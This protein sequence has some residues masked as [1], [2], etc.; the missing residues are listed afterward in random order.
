MNIVKKFSVFMAGLLLCLSILTSYKVEAQAT[1]AA[2]TADLLFTTFSRIFGYSYGFAESTDSMTT[3]HVKDNITYFINNLATKEPT[4]WGDYVVNPN[5]SARGSFLDLLLA[6]KAVQD[7]AVDNYGYNQLLYNLDKK[8]YSATGT[9]YSKQAD[10]AIDEAI[11]R[12][13]N[14][15][16][17]EF[18][19]TI[20][21]LYEALTDDA[22]AASVS[23]INRIRS[24]FDDLMIGTIAVSGYEDNN[25][26]KPVG[27][28]VFDFNSLERQ[29]VTIDG[30]DYLISKVLSFDGLYN[31][32]SGT[33]YR[34][35]FNKPYIAVCYK[36]YA[37]DK[38]MAILH[39]YNKGDFSGTVE[40]YNNNG[41]LRSSSTKWAT[42]SYGN[43]KCLESVP[44][45]PNNVTYISNYN[46]E[47]YFYD[48]SNY[49]TKVTNFL[50]ANMLKDNAYLDKAES[51]SSTAP[52]LDEALDTFWNKQLTVEDVVDLGAR[53]EALESAGTDTAIQDLTDTV[54]GLAV[55]LPDAVVDGKND[56]VQA[57]EGVGEAILTL[58]KAIWLEFEATLDAIATSTATATRPWEDGENQNNSLDI[59]NI[60]SGIILLL[61]I[62]FVLLRI[63]LHCMIFI[64]NV[65]RIPARPAF[66]PD[67]M[68][69]GLEYLNTLEIPGIGLSVYAFMMGLIYILIMFYAIGVLRKSV[70]RIKLPK[71]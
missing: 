26:M 19:A 40:I 18:D 14:M 51:I 46:Y 15:S 56:V 53:L 24:L 68:I 45:D 6:A 34:Y 7:T 54:N 2:T 13:E 42:E 57:V 49:Y 17:A 31:D 22:A 44:L 20:T 52:E 47:F 69:M 30:V 28:T 11:A 29:I 48:R 4:T 55:T 35:K 39:F 70:D 32:G 9:L 65:F 61:L 37:G 62:V 25:W 58:P 59:T 67:E 27:N 23:D 66:L 21:E 63:F 33:K 8:S 43:L 16:D 36:E 12:Y 64:I 3:N 41:T 71:Q 5:T 50:N 60:F 10:V 38:K 1:G